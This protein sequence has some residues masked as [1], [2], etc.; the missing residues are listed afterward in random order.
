MVL[1]QTFTILCF[2]PCFENG[3][4]KLIWLIPS[5]WELEDFC[6]PS[7]VWGLAQAPGF[8]QTFPTLLATGRTQG[9]RTSLSFPIQGSFFQHTSNAGTISKFTC[10]AGLT[11]K[12]KINLQ[13]RQDRILEAT[14]LYPKYHSFCL[15]PQPPS[16]GSSSVSSC[17]HFSDYSE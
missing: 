6:L 17:Q 12:Q 4:I 2:T 11:N 7:V 15:N 5:M 3:G 1:L 16:L 10:T 13:N 9:R 14:G 8:E